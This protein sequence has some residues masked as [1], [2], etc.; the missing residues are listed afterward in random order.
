[1]Y[2]AQYQLSSISTLTDSAQHM[3]RKNLFCKRDC[4]QAYHCLQM[5]V[6]QSVELLAFN[7]ASGTFAYR[8]LAHGLSRSLSAISSFIGKYLDPVIKADQCPQYVDDI[9]IA[10]KT[11]EQLIENLRAVFQRLRKSGLKLSMTKC[12]FGLQEL[13]FLG[14]T[15]KTKGMAPQKQKINKFLEKVKFPRSKKAIQ[16]YI[17]FL[18]Y[19]RNYIPRL[20]EL[21]HSILSTSQTTDTKTKNLIT[22]DIMTELSELNEALERCCQLALRQPLPGKQLVLMTDVSFQAAGYAVLI[23]D[24]PNQKYTSTSKTYAHI[25]YGSKT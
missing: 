1:M 9:G 15:I 14:R 10:A 19:Y 21:T 16:R 12:H 13:Y 24:D 25:A 3:A 18:I 23:E 5:A 11:T 2:E 22:P 6:Q 8:R 7:F 20:A 17:G 4:S